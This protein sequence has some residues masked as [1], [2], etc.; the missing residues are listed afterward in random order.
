MKVK[1][2]MSNKI[3]DLNRYQGFVRYFKNTSWLMAEQFLRIIAGLFIGIWVARYL[4]PQEFGM[5]SYAIAFTAIFSGVAKL[6]LDGIISREL[7]NNPDEREKYLGTAF[8]LKVIGAI[9][10][11]SLL[12]VIVPLAN[13]DDSTELFIFLISIGFVF[14]SFEV[15]EFYFQSKVLA[16]IVAICKVTQLA[17]SS[18]IKVYL[19]FAKADL[20]WFVIVIVFDTFSL[21]ISYC[22]SYHLQGKLIFYKKFDANIARRLLKDSLPLMLSTIVITIYMRI[23]QIMIKE[24]LGEYEVG[25]YS[26]AVRISEAFYFIPLLITAS[27]FPAIVNARNQNKYLYERRLQRLYTFMVWIALSIALP[28]TFL[29]NWLTIFLFGEVYKE[30]GEILMV[31]IWASIFVFLGV[32][33][34]KYLIAENLTKI[35][36]KRTFLGAISNVI[37]NLLLIPKYGPVGAA[38]ATLS[39]QFIANLGY[40][41]FDIQLRK[42]LKMKI[43]AI[44]MPWKAI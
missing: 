5:L 18:M 24:M 19:I 32:S 42:Q 38:I 37:L 8:W 28:M 10:V 27:V 34:S 30:A 35:A 33:F 17:L 16:R 15:I 6:G 7:I 9:I 3:L 31:H 13:N 2:L 4:G 43:S 39:A 40:D 29:S 44:F 22:I 23:D 36:F 26:A 25:I 14:Q 20:I 11:L 1:R 12:T 21:A 41:I